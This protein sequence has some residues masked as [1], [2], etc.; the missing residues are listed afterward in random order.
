VDIGG[1]REMLQSMGLTVPSKADKL[2]NDIEHQQHQQA[3]V[4]YKFIR[5]TSFSYPTVAQLASKLYIRDSGQH[6]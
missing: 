3:Q 2:M 6:Q 1:V 4:S 5:F